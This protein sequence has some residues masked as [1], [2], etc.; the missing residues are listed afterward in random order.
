MLRIHDVML[1]V[2]RLVAPHIQA[3]GRRNRDLE[4]QIT[5]SATSVVLNIAEGSGHQ[6]RARTNRYRIALG[7]ARETLSNLRAAEALGYV[8]RLDAGVVAGLNRVIGTLVVV[9]R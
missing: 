2:L 4:E 9:T 3:I 1:E 6:G 7:E 8:G 5:R